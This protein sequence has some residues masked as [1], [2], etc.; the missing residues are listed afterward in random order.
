MCAEKQVIHTLPEGPPVV[1]V[2]SL[3]GEIYLLRAKECV[4]AVEVY[5]VISFRLLRRLTVPYARSFTDMTSCKHFLCLYIC[6]PFVEC[7]HVLDSQGSHTKWPVND[8]PYCLSVNGDH[9]LIVTCRRVCKIKE[10]SPWGELL[11]DVTLPHDVVSPRHTIQ[12]NNGLFIVCHGDRGHPIH[13]VCKVSKDGSHVIHSYGDQQGS[14]IGHCDGPSHLA[15]DDKEFVFAVD[16]NNLR[17]TL[18][19]PTLGYIR[20]VVSC[21]QVNSEPR[22]LCLDVQ[23]RRLYVAEN[24]L[25]DG[26]FTAGRVV[27]FSL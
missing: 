2:T 16:V 18:L 25:R 4:N 14:D 8:A 20:Q 26:E 22:R 3:G 15:V 12:L 5:D 10:F 1:G 24:E 23:Q 19:S 9:N 21:D 7:V 17:V 13:R 6:D 11:R 27:V